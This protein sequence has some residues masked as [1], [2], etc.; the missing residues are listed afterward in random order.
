MRGLSWAVQTQSIFKCLGSLD[1]VMAS[2]TLWGL[3]PLLWGC[4]LGQ[5]SW[6]THLRSTSSH[7]ASLVGLTGAEDGLSSV[8]IE[9]EEAEVS[10][11]CGAPRSQPRLP[12][13]GN[14]GQLQNGSA[15][16][17]GGPQV[18]RG[19]SVEPSLRLGIPHIW[20]THSTPR[21]LSSAQAWESRPSPQ[22]MLS[23]QLFQH[24]P[25]NQESRKL[26]TGVIP[27]PQHH[28]SLPPICID[29]SKAGL[30]S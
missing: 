26:A 7:V 24:Q 10:R 25:E 6:V 12:R 5:P 14:L 13:G 27:S 16:S 22:G 19:H 11:E 20:L 1:T 2:A 8:T 23:K 4:R 21:S 28:K 9:G 18:E 17:P 30:H 3:K 29:V 15:S